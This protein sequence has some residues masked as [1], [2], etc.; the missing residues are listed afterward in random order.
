MFRLVPALAAVALALAGSALADDPQPPGTTTTT[1]TATQAITAVT[2]LERDVLGAMNQVRRSHGLVPLRLSSPL[3]T[4]ARAH[5]RS[6]AQYGYFTHESYDGTAF[7]RRIKPV[8][9]ARVGRYWGTGENMVWASPDLT[10]AQ[11]LDMWMRS[12]EH[13]KNLLTPAWRDVGVGGVHA[14]AAPGVYQGLD[15]T[16]VTTDF[17]VR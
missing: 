3:S 9:P 14:T 8:Y 1:T 2:Q 13:R 7:W 15:V 5:S 12:S 10:A 16:I 11:A 6:M 17:G 4:V